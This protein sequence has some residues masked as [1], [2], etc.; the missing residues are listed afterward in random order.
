MEKN[1]H[2]HA[3]DGIATYEERRQ[4]VVSMSRNVTGEYV[5]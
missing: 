4:S 1:T 3:D 5:D 2:D